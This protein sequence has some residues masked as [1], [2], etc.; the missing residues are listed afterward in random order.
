[1]LLTYLDERKTEDPDQLYYRLGVI[2]IDSEELRILK[3]ELNLLASRTMKRVWE[4]NLR[5]TARSRLRRG[6]GARSRVREAQYH[7][8]ELIR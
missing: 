2:M 4:P 3:T 6:M 8:A 1:M 7:S 5:Q